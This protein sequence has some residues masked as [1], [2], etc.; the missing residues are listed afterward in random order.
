MIQTGGGGIISKAGDENDYHHRLVTQI[1]SDK[2]LSPPADID[3][4][5]C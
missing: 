3:M 5:R 2:A 1:G 4:S